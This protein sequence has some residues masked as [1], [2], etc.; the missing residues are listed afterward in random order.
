LSPEKSFQYGFG[1]V[2]TPPW[3]P[4]LMASVDYYNIRIDNTIL[5]GGIVNAT[6]VDAVL[7]GC[8]GP[9]QNTAYCSLIRR[10]PVSGAIVQINSL[11]ANFGIARVTGIDY[12]LGYDMAKAQLNLPFPGSFSFDLQLEEQYKNTQT[13]ADGTVSSFVGFFQYANE[14][15]N[16]HWKGLAT[17]EYNLAPFTFHWDT[18]YI[19]GMQSFDGGPNRAGNEIPA[20]YYHNVS[21]AYDLKNLG[22]VKNIHLVAGVNN[23]L[24][25]DPPFLTADSICKCNTLA[26]P[27][28]VIGRFVFVR[29]STTF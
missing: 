24:D 15:I 19:E 1:A 14:V 7:L 12:E 22:T 17:I 21:V 28:D 2:F 25:K 13:N 9:A 16:P 18:R 23:L 5:T 11:N 8:Y 26:G 27:Y 29:A 10:D 3:T 20:Y 4:G 6:S